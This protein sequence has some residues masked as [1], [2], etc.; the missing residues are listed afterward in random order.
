VCLIL[1]Y[2]HG[3]SREEIGKRL[4]LSD[5]QVRGHLQYAL[6]LLRKTLVAQAG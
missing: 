2:E 3:L 6:T 4:G 1:R 5:T